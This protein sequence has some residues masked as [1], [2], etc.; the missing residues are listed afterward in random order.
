MSAI[1]SRILSLALVISAACVAPACIIEADDDDDASL[2]VVNESDFAIVE[3]F[4][5]AV[6]DPDWGPNLLRGDELFPGESIEIVDIRCDF[7][8]ALL[9]DEDGVECELFSI[10]LCFDDA[11]WVIRNNTCT[12]FDA[13][14]TARE[15]AAAAGDGG[16]L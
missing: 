7:Y 4:L 11:T 6:D 15:A 13:A 10:D 2:L 5:T 3:L 9:V 8:D 12:V 1:K 14:K 16:A